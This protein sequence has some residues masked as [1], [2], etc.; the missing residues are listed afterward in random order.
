MAR[1]LLARRQLAYKRRMAHRWTKRLGQRQ[2]GPLGLVWLMAIG[3]LDAR[4]LANRRMAKRPLDILVESKQR[5]SRC[6]LGR[7]DLRVLEHRSKL[8]E[9][10]G[11]YG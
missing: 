3:I 10:D 2:L 4:V 5:L 6:K 1:R 7:L 8:D 9:L 11:M